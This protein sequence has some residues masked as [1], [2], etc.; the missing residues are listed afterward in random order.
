[1]SFLKK[2]LTGHHGSSHHGNVTSSDHHGNSHDKN[3]TSSGHHKGS[4][5]HYDNS[6]SH[7]EIINENKASNSGGFLP[8]IVL[9]TR[10][11]GCGGDVRAGDIFCSHCGI[12]I[13]PI[14]CQNCGSDIK[15][16]NKFCS[17]CGANTS[18]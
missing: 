7:P 8:N 9:S 13:S 14:I 1:M 16:G 5:S 2:L 10:C 3:R 18:K 11:T 15:P 6:H 12:K 17:Q 4:N